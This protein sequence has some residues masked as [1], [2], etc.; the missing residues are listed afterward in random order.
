MG[1][2]T[3]SM[4]IFNSYFDITRGYVQLSGHLKSSQVPE[5]RWIKKTDENGSSS[6]REWGHTWGLGKCLL[7][8]TN[9]VQSV[10]VNG[11]YGDI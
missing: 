9:S 5:T 2:S 7:T 10:D 8:V 1:K 11:I 6:A 4:V 3:I